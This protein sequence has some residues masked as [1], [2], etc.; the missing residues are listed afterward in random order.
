MDLDSLDDGP[1]PLPP[2]AGRAHDASPAVAQPWTARLRSALM[3]YLPVLL[4]GVLA[5]AS[6][7][8]VKRTPV[9][10]TPAPPG[11]ASREPDYEMRAFSVQHYTAAG[12]AQGVIEGDVVR[13]FPDNDRLEIEGVRLRWSDPAGR[14]LR[15]S[16]ARALVFNATGLVT[17]EGGAR[18][19]RDA[20]Q[21]GDAPLEFTGE[22]MVFDTRAGRVNSREPITLRQGGHVFEAG[23][24]SYDHASRQ[25]ELGGGVRGRLLPAGLR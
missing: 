3:G 9:Q 4:M 19:T 7:W 5:A 25:A 10:E 15:A 12:P 18:V 17:L 16:A 11:A 6:W 8:L 22:R 1:V 23:S 13:H 20:D 21:A 14:M 2:L 24:L